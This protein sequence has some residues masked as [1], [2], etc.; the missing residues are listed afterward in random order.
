MQPPQQANLLSP[1]TPLQM[2]DKSQ[3]KEIIQKYRHVFLNSL[4]FEMVNADEMKFMAKQYDEIESEIIMALDFLAQHN[5]GDER[6]Y[7]ETY[8]VAVLPF[9]IFDGKLIEPKIETKKSYEE[10]LQFLRY[11]KHNKG[12]A[13]HHI[14]TTTADKYTEG[15]P[16]I[17]FDDFK[18][19]DMDKVDEHIGYYE[20]LSQIDIGREKRNWWGSSGAFF[21]CL[22]FAYSVYLAWSEPVTDSDG[23][24]EGYKRKAEQDRII[25]FL[26]K[27]FKKLAVEPI[28]DKTIKSHIYNQAKQHQFIVCNPYFVAKNHLL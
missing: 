14:A 12:M 8:A 25:Y 3:S 7:V 20:G 23:K 22:C 16:P 17:V 6:E 27:F 24:P 19:F 2:T 4:R 5:F 11:I 21:R 9:M 10:A 26:E 15:H 28:S 1:Y 13:N 18:G